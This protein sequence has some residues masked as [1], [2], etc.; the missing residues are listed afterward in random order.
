[1]GTSGSLPRTASELPMVGLIG[2]LALAVA[3]GIRV[4]RTA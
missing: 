1:V 2:L 4:A 3:L